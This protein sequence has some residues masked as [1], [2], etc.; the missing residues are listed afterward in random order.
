VSARRGIVILPAIAGVN[1]YIRRIAHRLGE[2]GWES[3][4]VDYFEGNAP[5][6]LSS[7]QKIVQA[8]AQVDDTRVMAQ[9]REAVGR[10]QARGAGAVGA[11][12][13][14]IGGSYALLAGCEVDG[15]SAVANYY[16]GVRYSQLS[17]RKP[18]APLDRAGALRVPMIAHYG[19]VDRF[20]PPADVDALQA[21]LD[22]NGRTF[23]L[24]RYAGSPHAFDEDFRPAFRPAA[25][26]EAWAR[27]MTFMAWYVKGD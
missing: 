10:L 11:L 6:D 1:D 2:A 14:C 3:E 18:V 25:S 27:T 24:F 12:G 4:L 15:L 9:T 16:G 8:V 7:P 19:S 21:A 5:P 17:R 20:V 23:E 26:R 13:Y 22:A